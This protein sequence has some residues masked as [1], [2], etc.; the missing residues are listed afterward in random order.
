MNQNLKNL[1]GLVGAIAI[2]AVAYAALS[3][4]N[5][6]GKVIEPSSF[7]SFSASGEGK[8]TA[9]PDIA[10]F[11]FQVITEGGTDIAALQTQ[12][13]AKMNKA[14]DF[15]K[16]QG[17][18]DKDIK[19]Q[20]Y[21]LEPRYETT[22]CKVVTAPLI[23]RSATE[24]IALKVEAS[25][26]SG[27]AVAMSP[28][29]A[30]V[31]LSQT[32][33]PPSIVGYTITQAVNV[34]IRD[35]QKIS[36]IMSGVIKNGANQVGSLSFTIDDQTKAQDEARAEAIKKAKAKAEAMAEAGGFKIGRLLGIQEGNIYP[37]YNVRSM[38]G[39]VA[40]KSEAVDAAPTIQPGSQEISINVTLQYE[41]E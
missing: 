19:T 18:E 15:V 13:T 11:S 28:A 17:V 37:I 34:K 31:S 38:D 29:I 20:Y 16:A 12:N 10:A 27:S 35:F 5:S 3:Y 4:V 14:I 40:A 36:D 26:S 22:S 7:R 2:L 39:M 33:P 30:P 8:T 6:Y 24:D 21:N 32:C 23:L 41:I 9:I 1:L 25:G